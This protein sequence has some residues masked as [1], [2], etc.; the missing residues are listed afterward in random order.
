M[1]TP[2]RIT[3]IEFPADDMDRAKAFYAAV[4]GWEFQPMEG[5]PDYELFS[6]GEGT[7]GAIGARGT[8]TGQQVRVF[9]TVPDLEQALAAAQEHGGSLVEGPVDLEGTGRY[10]VV[11]DPEGSEIALW[12]DPPA[13]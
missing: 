4:A 5:F 8:S 1:T 3:H 2:A 12:Q 13:G 6:T 9:I 10:V 7:G 11:T